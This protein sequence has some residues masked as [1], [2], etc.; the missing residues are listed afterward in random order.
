M[1]LFRRKEAAPPPARK[2]ASFLLALG[3]GKAGLN[4][5]AYDRLAAEGYSECVVAYSCVNKIAAACASVEPQ[6]Y[7]R[8]KGGKLDRVT[9]HPLLSLLARPN[10]AQS[11]PEFFRHLV[12]YHQLAGN[13]Y[14]LGNG[15]EGQLRSALPTELQLLNPSKVRV[16]PGPGFLPLA[17]EYRPDGTRTLKYPVDQVSGRSAVC[18]FK[19]F[20]P[21][22]PWYGMSPLSAAALGIDIHN[23]GG[24]WNKRLIEN[25][26]RPSGALV[27]KAADGK[28]A[29]LTDEQYLRLKEMIDAQFS[30]QANA[31]R[32]MLLEGGLEWQEMSLNPKD[33][34][35]L[36]GKHAAARD[37]ALAFGVPPQLVGIP[38]SATFANYEQATLSFWTDTVLPLLALVL[39][40]LNRWLVPL[41]GDDLYL[42]FDEEGIP[43]LEPRRQQKATRVNAAGYLTVN[44]KRR[45]MGLDDIEGGD[46]VLVQASTIPLELAGQMDLPEPGSAADDEGD[47]V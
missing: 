47:D 24:R 25:G 38:D 16:E 8:G 31:G 18:Q 9:D 37:V 46:T 23:A 33:M 35:F 10:A 6:L 13:A 17:F 28:P 19:T 22:N 5:A 43:A 1:R 36:Q 40:G 30:G 15:L 7:R 34:D 21:L 42:W 41:Y 26:A 11:G 44:E 4:G 12:S 29:E 2:S 32:P 27:V 3:A 14:V 39:E 20:N 45:A